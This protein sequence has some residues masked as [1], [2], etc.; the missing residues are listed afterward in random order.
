MRDKDGQVGG[1]KEGESNEQDILIRGCHYRVREKPDAR[2]I[3]MI[4][5]G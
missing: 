1:R 5:Q 2:E 4:P 3:P